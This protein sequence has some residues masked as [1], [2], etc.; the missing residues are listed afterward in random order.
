MGS[1]CTSLLICHYIVFMNIQ[2]LPNFVNITHCV[3]FE[4][5]MFCWFCFDYPL[6]LIFLLSSIL[7]HSW[8]MDFILFTWLLIKFL[9]MDHHPL[10]EHPMLQ[11]IL[12]LPVNIVEMQKLCSALLESHTQKLHLIAFM[13][14]NEVIVF[15][16]PMLN[17]KPKTIKMS[18]TPLSHLYRLQKSCVCKISKKN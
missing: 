16:T 1:I 5:A 3:S 17:G 4:L 14:N 10:S 13:M 15:V 8:S 6:A 11:K 7:T 9:H 18:N 2:S 12:P